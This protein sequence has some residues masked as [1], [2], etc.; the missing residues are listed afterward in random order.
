MGLPNGTRRTPD[1]RINTF[2][3]QQ[4]EQ[5]TN[6][7][8]ALHRFYIGL[9]ADFTVVP[10]YWICVKSEKR[11]IVRNVRMSIFNVFALLGGLALFLFGMDVMGK[12]LER[13]A[14]NWKRS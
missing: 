11:T 5:E 3:T 14:G 13:P 10:V 9:V 6:P 8:R 4:T 1:R 7:A 2:L 12:A